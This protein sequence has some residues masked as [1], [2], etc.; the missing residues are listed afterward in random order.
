MELR[1]ENP[2][3]HLE[4]LLVSPRLLASR[5]H[6]HHERALVP[7]KVLHQLRLT[8]EIDD[9]EPPLRVEGWVLRV[10]GCRLRIDG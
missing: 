3:L 8:P 6:P 10:E 7:G 4:L 9:G 2:P 5:E 1:R